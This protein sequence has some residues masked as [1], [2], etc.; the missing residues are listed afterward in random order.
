M[1]WKVLTLGLGIALILGITVAGCGG[2]NEGGTTGEASSETSQQVESTDKENEASPFG[3]G[4]IQEE[5]NL[6]EEID[7]QLAAKGEEIFK[8]MCTACHKIDEKYIG[9]AIRGVTEKRRPEWIMNMIL[10][11]ER[12]IQEDPIAKQ[13]VIEFNGAVMAN[14][15][16]SKEEARAILEYFRKLDNQS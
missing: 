14:Q 15:G 2:G 4:P 13:L 3:V 5:M 7:E 11:P 16:L 9:P 1:K 8:S 6:P 10:A 12:M